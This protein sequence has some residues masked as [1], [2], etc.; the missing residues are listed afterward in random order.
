MPWPTTAVASSATCDCSR[1]AHA[2]RGAAGERRALACAWTGAASREHW[3]GGARDVDFFDMKGLVERICAP[4]LRRRRDGDRI[5]EPWLV[6][7]A[8][9]AVSAARR[10]GRRDRTARPGCCRA[11]RAA[12][13]RTPVYVA[14]IDLDALERSRR[15]AVPPGRTA[16]AAIRP[17]RATFRFSWMPRSRRQPFATPMRGRA[18][19]TLSRVREFDRYQGKGIPD[20]QGEPVA[21]PGIPVTRPNAHRRRGPVGDGCDRSSALKAASTRAIQRVMRLET[22]SL[23]GTI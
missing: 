19:P 8:T 17:S 20:G 9:A 18:P 1:S 10:T 21:A 12:D 4:P 15:P 2:S 14:E 3:S 23:R 6:P 5:R 13:R 22:A 16:A 11:A 7:G